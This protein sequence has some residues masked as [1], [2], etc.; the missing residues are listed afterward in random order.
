MFL[1][2]YIVSPPLFLHLLLAH[3][4]GLSAL[5]PSFPAL[6]EVVNMA[7]DQCTL[8]LIVLFPPPPPALFGLRPVTEQPLRLSNPRA[9]VKALAGGPAPSAGPGPPGSPAETNL[10][11][12][13]RPS[14]KGGCEINTSGCH[15]LPSTPDNS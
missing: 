1:S 6:G 10:L 8:R 3:F 7:K 5:G 4:R 11:R 13:T 2:I 14:R 15:L 12:Q 9:G